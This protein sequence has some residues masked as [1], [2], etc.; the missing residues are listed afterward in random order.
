MGDG[1]YCDRSHGPALGY[2]DTGFVKVGCG[3]TVGMGPEQL[4]PRVIEGVAITTGGGHE[5]LFFRIL[6]IDIVEC[7][8]TDYVFRE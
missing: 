4:T 1:E 6:E 8:G 3:G 2:S 5:D 7:D